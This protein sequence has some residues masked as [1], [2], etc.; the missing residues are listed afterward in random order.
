MT[1]LKLCLTLL[2]LFSLQ[3]CI[4]TNSNYYI[5]SVASQPTTFYANRHKSIGVEKITVPAYLYKRDIAVANSSSQISLQGSAS[6]GED[7]DTGLTN[8]LITFLQNKF[9]QPLVNAY[10]WNVDKQP[11]FVVKVHITRFIAQGDKVYLSANWE[12]EKMKTHK[13]K[14]KLFHTT[15]PTTQDVTEIVSSMDRAFAQLEENIARDIRY[16]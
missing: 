13:I 11:D 7:L 12:I 10:P 3:G 15:V 14:A 8:R 1:K 5:L 2:I 4:S 9:Q 16:Y 6:W